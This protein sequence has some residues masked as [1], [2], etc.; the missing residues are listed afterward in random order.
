MKNQAAL[1]CFASLFYCGVP[2][3]P[4]LSKTGLSVDPYFLIL[5]GLSLCKG[6]WSVPRRC[7]E[8]RRFI[9]DPASLTRDIILTRLSF[10]ICLI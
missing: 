10:K 8:P 6:P 1:T 5:S 2:G 4:C 7:P 3:S 9:G